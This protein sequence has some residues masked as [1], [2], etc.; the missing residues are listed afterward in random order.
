MTWLMQQPLAIIVGGLVVEL[1]LFLILQQTG[2]KW[3]VW[4][5]AAVALLLVGGV[6]LERQI[7]TP[8]E[9][10]RAKLYEIAADVQRNDID[11]VVAHM[12]RRAAADEE[13]ARTVLKRVKF[14]EVS[15]KEISEFNV[16]DPPQRAS[17]TV[18]VKAVGEMGN[19]RGTG[20]RD[21]LVEFVLEDD[22]W[23]I[24]GWKELGDPLRSR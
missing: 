20:L 14:S 18:R 1:L 12:S 22:V 3:V 13:R 5:M 9:A 10:V 4:T 21:F 23:K 8:Q 16:A 6:L 17:A 19:F 7:V 2:K 15:V 11:A 24:R